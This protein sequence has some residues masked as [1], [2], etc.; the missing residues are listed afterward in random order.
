MPQVIVFDDLEKE[1]VA[2][3]ESLAAALDDTVQI[4]VFDGSKEP[5]EGMSHELHIEKWLDELPCDGDTALVVCDK[6]LGIYENLPG[7]SATAVS[8]ASFQLG[9][10]FCQYSR[11][12]AEIERDFA[13]FS[14]LSRWDSEDITLSGQSPEEWA[15][16]AAELLRGFVD[17][18]GALEAR[19]GG[20]RRTP[21]SSLAA[22]LERPTAE[23]KL[24]LYGSGD[25]LFL[26]E[27]FGFYDPEKPD[28]GVLLQRLPRL[29]GKWLRLSILRFPGVLANATA[30]A[31]YLNI[32]EDDFA[33]PGKRAVFARAEYE[34][35]F[36]ASAQGP[37]WWREELDVLLGDAGVEDGL[38]LLRQ[39]GLEADECVDPQTGERAGY[40]CML[41]HD[42]VSRENSRGGISWFP[43]GAD[44]ARIRRDKF[45]TLNALVG[46][47]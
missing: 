18:A 5:R 46:L 47:F 41:T 15:N 9:L 45:E 14:R 27:V 1:R 29:L 4:H 42:P 17:I 31:S 19:G 44:L 2:V 38:T 43:Q 10:P 3:A 39:Q 30:A 6:E 40:Y 25:Q 32:A 35:P 33:E 13:Q 12:G 26:R 16:E 21:A 8:V 22:I 20:Q 7:L 28:E 24:A 34:G 23:S 11:E 36:S 37:W